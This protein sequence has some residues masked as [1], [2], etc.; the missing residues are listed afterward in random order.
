MVLVSEMSKK[1]VRSGDR[2]EI[3]YPNDLWEL[4]NEKRAH[5]IQ[6]MDLLKRY[7]IRSFIHGSVA[8]GFISRKSDIDVVIPYILPSFSVE[9][10]LREEFGI[11]SFQKRELVQAT[12]YHTPKAH[13]SLDEL[14]IV[15]FPL[16]GLRSQE[17]EFYKFGGKL[18]LN[19]LQTEKRV[20][21]V[22]KRLLL[23]EPSERGHFEWPIIGRES[24]V[25]KLVGVNINIVEERV[26]ILLRRNAIGRTGTYLKQVLRDNEIFEEVLKKIMDSDPVV[27][28][29][30]RK[31]K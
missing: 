16:V 22:D 14:T 24:E 29:R 3:V 8:R 11:N 4:L 17:H 23:I 20:A 7:N 12:P 5:A 19:G 31:G 10:A 21:G 27:R 28:R 15:T 25:A 6:I 13:I 18:D 1:P 30:V 2:V 9:L 26:K